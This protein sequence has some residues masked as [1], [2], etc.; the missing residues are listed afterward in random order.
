MTKYNSYE[1]EQYS[2]HF[3]HT[4]CGLSCYVILLVTVSNS[5]A[6]LDNATYFEYQLAIKREKISMI[7]LITMD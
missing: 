2:K 5:Y 4:F 7:Y 6:K 3:F 1:K